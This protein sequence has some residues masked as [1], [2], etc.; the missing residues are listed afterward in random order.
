MQALTGNIMALFLTN[1]LLE[2]I[3][4]LVANNTTTTAAT[5]RQELLTRLEQEQKSDYQRFSTSH[6]PEPFEKI[7]LD[8]DLVNA[9]NVSV[10]FR[11]P[12][13]CHVATLPS[14]TRYLGILTKSNETGV[15]DYYKG[16]HL[17]QAKSLTLQGSDQEMEMPLVWDN[18]VDREGPGCELELRRDHKEYFYV[19]DKMGTAT[20]TVPNPAEFQAYGRN[21]QKLHGIIVICLIRCPWQRCPPGAL[22]H[23]E[24][25]NGNVRLEV[26]G[27]LV[28]NVTDLGGECLVLRGATR[29][30]TPVS[31]N[32]DRA[33]CVASKSLEGEFAASNKFSN[34]TLTNKLAIS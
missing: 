1:I 7:P 4:D 32:R 27:Q 18:N 34:Y 2:A 23:D 20:L 30:W 10:F 22:R 29:Q 26:N 24:I 31:S 19:S 6:P 15:H 5:N 14:M 17:E 8:E 13:I 33:V 21:S 11:S 9:A 16:I 25:R 12:S 3:D 28:T